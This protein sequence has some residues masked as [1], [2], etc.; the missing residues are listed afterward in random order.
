MPK[1]VSDSTYQ[2]SV[3]IDTRTLNRIDK[4]RDT[5]DEQTGARPQRSDIVRKAIDYGIDVYCKQY[6]INVSAASAS[7]TT[8]DTGTAP[9]VVREKEESELV[10]VP[11]KKK[12]AAVIATSSKKKN[13]SKSAAR[14]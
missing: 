5:L 13:G 7:T 6:N 12:E 4:I 1:H 3:R 2:L 11:S 10:T 8:I 14:A 9:P